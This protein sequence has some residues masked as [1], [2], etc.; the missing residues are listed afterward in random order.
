V[1]NQLH[2]PFTSQP[3]PTGQKFGW[4]PELVQ[5]QW[6]REKYSLTAP[7]G[8]QTLVTESTAKSIY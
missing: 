3:V 8:N 7:A 1:S 6:Q 4:T 5:M 2:S